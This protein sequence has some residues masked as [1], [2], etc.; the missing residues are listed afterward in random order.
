MTNQ[1]EK[2]AQELGAKPGSKGNFVANCPAHEDTEE[3]LRFNEKNGEALLCCHRGCSFDEVR[4]ELIR[5]GCLSMFAKA[6]PYRP[7]DW[8]EFDDALVGTFGAWV[9]SPFYKLSRVY[10]FESET[11]KIVGFKARLSPDKVLA[12]DYFGLSDNKVN[13]KPSFPPYMLPEVL[14]AISA[15]HPIHILEKEE[16]ANLASGLGL[17]ATC[18]GSGKDP[19]PSSYFHKFKGARCVIWTSIHLDRAARIAAALHAQGAIVTIATAPNELTFAEWFK[20]GAKKEAISALVKDTIEW[21]PPPEQMKRSVESGV[22]PP[23]DNEFASE[24]WA[25]DYYAHKF[26]EQVRYV[27]PNNEW[28]HNTKTHWEQDKRRQHRELVKK[29]YAMIRKDMGH[30]DATMRPA[31]D[32]LASKANTDSGV[33]SILSMA[34]SVDSIIV[35]SSEMDAPH[36]RRYFNCASGLIDLRT[37][38]IGPHDASLLITQFSPC[39]VEYGKKTPKYDAFLAHL[40]TKIDEKGERVPDEELIHYIKYQLAYCLTG[41]TG[42]QHF[43]MWEGEPGTGKGTLQN[44]IMRIMGPMSGT[45]DPASL[46]ESKQ[47]SPGVLSDLATMQA[48]RAVFVDEISANHK[49]DEAL[50]KALTGQS[51][52]KAKGMHENMRELKADAKFIFTCNERPPFSDDDA[53]ARRLLMVRL[54]NKFD[55]PI[56]DYENVLYDEEGAAILGELI[57]LCCDGYDNQW[58]MLED[59]PKQIQEWTKEAVEE[60]NH[61]KQWWAQSVRPMPGYFLKTLDMFLDYEKHLKEQRRILD[62]TLDQFGR[63][64]SKVARDARMPG[65]GKHKDGYGVRGLKGVCLSGE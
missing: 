33:R 5:I 50:I 38:E 32:K 21:A 62:L 42:F 14:E 35:H 11:G 45:L 12:Y 17:R 34:S 61:V 52:F 56:R 24:A 25:G 53:L 29:M 20:S 65:V 1:V 16:E 39:K 4:N 27:S 36:T 15:G 40:F 49:L 57:T 59:I 44:L 13:R 60:A 3:S 30:I 37:A 6:S 22:M 23:S 28:F 31:L 41:E 51:P 10:T 9:D 8:K 46:R 58:A 47:R 2:I 7:D 48:K 19:I 54:E 18:F 26:A 43:M 64:V 63:R 55:V